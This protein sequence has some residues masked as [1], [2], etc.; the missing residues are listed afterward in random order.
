MAPWC[1][2]GDRAV[3]APS[4]NYRH[5]ANL[6]VLV[7]ADSRLVLAVG[8]PL[9]GNRNDCRAYQESGVD[10]HVGDAGTG[11]LIPH[12]L[13]PGQVPA[14]RGGAQRRPSEG[15][16]PRR[17]RAGP[18]EGLEDPA[19]LRSPRGRP[20]QAAGGSLACTTSLWPADPEAAKAAPRDKRHRCE[21]KG[22]L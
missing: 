12:R 2:P 17:A 9:P 16:R 8:E 13:R 20:K 11:L 4:K 14:W 10:Q 22:S 21:L 6:Q 18:D 19:G 7:H 1:P 5:A 3:A 15:A